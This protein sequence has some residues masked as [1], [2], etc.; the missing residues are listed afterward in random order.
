MTGT[1]FIKKNQQKK[2]QL[3]VNP[4]YVSIG[5]GKNHL[6]CNNVLNI[7]ICDFNKH[8]KSML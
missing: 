5:S 6:H 7:I 1:S 2:K 8:S 4:M 3:K